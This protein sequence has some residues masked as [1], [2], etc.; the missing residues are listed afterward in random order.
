[1]YLFLIEDKMGSFIEVIY[2]SW[3]LKRK[4]ILGKRNLDK[5]KSIYKGVR[6]GVI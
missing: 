5:G 2:L 3:I 6:K 1:M 4:D